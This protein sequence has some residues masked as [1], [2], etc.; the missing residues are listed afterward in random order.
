MSFPEHGR[1][2]FTATLVRGHIAK[3]HIPYL[4]W[5]K[6]QGWETWVA[7]KNDYPDGVC[8][9]RYCDHF[10][11]IDFARSP[12]SK[13]TLIAYSQL[14]ALFDKESFD[15]VHTHTPV[16]GVLTRL[17]ARKARRSGT[18][19]VY[20]AHGFHFY[21][22]APVVN[23]MLWYPVERFMSRLTD[24]LIVINSED[25]AIAKRFSHAPVRRM[26]GMG[27]DLSKFEFSKQRKM[28]FRKELENELGLSSGDYIVF[29]IGDLNRNKNHRLLVECLPNLST[30]IHLVIAGTGPMRDGLI[31]IA[32]SKGVGDRLH[33]LGFRDDVADVLEI[34]NL[35]CLPSLREG[36]PISLLE[37]MASGTVCLASDV[38]G[39][40]D[41]LGEYADHCIVESYDVC[42][43]SNCIGSCIAGDEKLGKGLKDRAALFSLERALSVQKKI[44]I[45]LLEGQ[46]KSVSD[47]ISSTMIN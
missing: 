16:G 36:L 4:K 8:E 30:N 40:R 11:N 24:A 3:F 19:V 45:E 9:I 38:R 25:E 21:K 13:Q 37:A 18:K 6:E 41:L 29:A 43:W 46:Q 33:V 27:I 22:G 7:A 44:Y 26:P 35:F 15:I 12:F 32:D 1:V 28:A 20:T 31:A 34:S 5:F 2:L 47:R 42:D 39:A 23:W 17:A 14:K 10:V